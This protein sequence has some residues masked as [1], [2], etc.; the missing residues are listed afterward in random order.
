MD[1]QNHHHHQQKTKYT[2]SPT[3]SRVHR[4]PNRIV[5]DPTPNQQ[6]LYNRIRE[7]EDRH[8]LQHAN[9]QVTDLL[10]PP[11]RAT[12]MSRN[13]SLTG[14]GRATNLSQPPGSTSLELPGSTAVEAADATAEPGT[15]PRGRRKQPLKMEA[16]F[17]TAIKRSLRLVCPECKQ[18][19]IT[20]HCYD[21]S[22]LEEAYQN[23]RQ[24]TTSNSPSSR[25]SRQQMPA[26]N[27][28][29]RL[30]IQTR[31]NIPA[32]DLL[33]LST[34]NGS[35]IATPS[36]MNYDLDEMNNE[37]GEAPSARHHV[38]DIVSQFTG[39]DTIPTSGVVT[40]TPAG[41]YNPGLV[42]TGA[43]QVD[44]KPF[45]IGSE[46]LGQSG[47]WKC[48]FSN[49]VVSLPN[50]VPNIS[51]DYL[52][53]CPWTGSFQGL[54]AHFRASHHAFQDPIYSCVCMSCDATTFGPSPPDQC[55]QPDCSPYGG[56]SWKRWYYGHMLVESIAPSTP[57]LTQ[58]GESESGFSFDNRGGSYHQPSPGGSHRA[59]DWPI[60]GSSGG[61]Y[62]RS[63][64]S[65]YTCDAQG[66]SSDCSSFNSA[67][68]AGP[69]LCP[70]N[71]GLPIPV[72]CMLAISLLVTILEYAF[73]IK[74]ISARCM[75]AVSSLSPLSL[76]FILCG[77]TATWFFRQ[78]MVAWNLHRLEQF[79]NS[80]SQISHSQHDPFS[81]DAII[82]RFQFVNS[83]NSPRHSGGITTDTD[84]ND[85]VTTKGM[86][87]L[88]NIR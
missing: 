42:T 80:A 4:T 17:K 71:S 82:I 77:F 79:I 25:N 52:D 61:N 50:S 31:A 86:P 41:P 7:E 20:C 67:Y 62:Y 74:D 49:Q 81:S 10:R 28:Q 83:S 37:S 68:Y 23:M 88:S 32:N 85:D 59:F 19:K 35:N 30:T 76:M 66:W 72:V 48:E 2:K 51:V 8:A 73:Q 58:S 75:A 40:T 65:D 13:G 70:L 56:G 16:R 6:L 34:T 84:M 63:K 1:L 64:G 36:E 15:R 53:D 22:R 87:L 26:I 24:R 60:N 46:L 5:F 11:S 78:W 47:L 45:P 39:V 14:E 12:A 57:G 44:P 54:E 55:I 3:T 33:G 38:R 43:L 18:R 21:L 69:N 27:T 9:Q 29:P